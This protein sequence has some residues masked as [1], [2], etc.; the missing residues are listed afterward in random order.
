MG[1]LDSQ[2]V[3]PHRQRVAQLRLARPKLPVDLRQRP[4][5]EPPCYCFVVVVVNE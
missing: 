2:R 4:R 1:Q 3:Q 5:L